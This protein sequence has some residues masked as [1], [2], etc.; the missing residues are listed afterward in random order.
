M[1]F[2]VNVIH[3]NAFCIFAKILFMQRKYTCM[4]FLNAIFH[5]SYAFLFRMHLQIHLKNSKLVSNMNAWNLNF[6]LSVTLHQCFHE[7]RKLEILGKDFLSCSENGNQSLKPSQKHRF[8]CNA[9]INNLKFS[10]L[11]IS[12]LKPLYQRQRWFDNRKPQIFLP[13]TYRNSFTQTLL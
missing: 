7:S 11:G 12:G 2:V 3:F 9:F 5:W 10:D 8:R 6:L 4:Y 13:Q 1:H